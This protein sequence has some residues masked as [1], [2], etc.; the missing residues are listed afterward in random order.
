MAKEPPTSL[1]ADSEKRRASRMWSWLAVA[2]SL[3]LILL[4][5]GVLPHTHSAQASQIRQ[6]VQPADIVQPP[7]S[8]YGTVLA[9]IDN[10]PVYSNG[11]NVNTMQ[12]GPYGYQYQCVELIQRYFALKWHY[13][14][15]CGGVNYAYQMIEN[16]P[17]V[18]R[19]NN[20][21]PINAIWNPASASAAGIWPGPQRGDA[22]VFAPASDGTNGAG[23]VALITDVSGGNVYFVEQNF[24]RYGTGFL[25]IVGNNYI[26][27]RG[28]YAVRGWLHASINTGGGFTSTRLGFQL[29]LPGIFEYGQR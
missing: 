10:I 14:N 7:W 29:S 18:D 2:S 20:P 25:P 26:A 21:Q 28:V 13:P 5:F 9:S 8:A 24:S 12:N 4:S 22:L 3:L 6:H 11:S 15:T 19:N 1:G 17:N 27:P 16:H 23:H